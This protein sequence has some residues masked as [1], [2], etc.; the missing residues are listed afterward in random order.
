MT[1][2]GVQG[3]SRLAAVAHEAIRRNVDDSRTKV[4]PVVSS[5]ADGLLSSFLEAFQPSLRLAE[6]RAQAIADDL[7]HQRA[8]L[9]TSLLQPG[10]FDRRMERAAAA[11]HATLD[12]ALH[13]CQLRLDELAR[14]R[15]VSID[16]RLAFGLVAR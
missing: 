13:R 11:Q 6:V 10:L 9:A 2:V 7:H 12:E 4:E 8:R 3:E 15:S 14:C 5:M 16:S 1:L